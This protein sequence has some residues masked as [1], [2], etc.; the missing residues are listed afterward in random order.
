MIKLIKFKKQVKNLNEKRIQTKYKR[1]HKRIKKYA[2][3]LEHI[4]GEN[5]EGLIRF[6]WR[7]HRYE[8]KKEAK[9]I[10]KIEMQKAK[11]NYLE[12][13]AKIKGYHLPKYSAQHQSSLPLHPLF[14]KLYNFLYAKP[15]S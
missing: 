9:L 13:I 11:I 6:L 3:I 2:Q 12:D 7:N 10:Q 15:T 5:G 4:R 8:E 14:Q 1:T